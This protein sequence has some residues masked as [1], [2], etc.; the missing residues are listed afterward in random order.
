MSWGYFVAVQYFFVAL[1]ERCVLRHFVA[2][3]LI[4]GISDADE[5]VYVHKPKL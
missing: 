2:E 1:Y 3:P 4:C 5:A